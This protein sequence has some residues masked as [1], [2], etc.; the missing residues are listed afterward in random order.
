MARFPNIAEAQQDANAVAVIEP[1]TIQSNQHRGFL[2]ADMRD[3]E[4]ARGAGRGARNARIAAGD[5][6]A[7]MRR[8]DQASF[9]GQSR[10]EIMTMMLH[11]IRRSGSMARSI[12]TRG[13]GAVDC[14]SI[15]PS[16]WQGAQADAFMAFMF[17]TAGLPER[18]ALQN[19]IPGLGCYARFVLDRVDGSLTNQAQ[20]IAVA[21]KSAGA[22]VDPTD[23]GLLSSLTGL[24]A[25]HGLTPKR[26]VELYNCGVAIT[27]SA[28][29]GDYATS[30]SNSDCMRSWYENPWYLGAGAAVLIGAVW[31]ATKKKRS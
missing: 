24:V 10:E 27:K 1:L 11:G 4:A 16:A 22:M 25:A 6:V 23:S 28:G 15:P 18:T 17:S 5:P 7:R 2:N 30:W 8:S 19:A 12:Q 3:F 13:L 26:A 20:E 31:F 29:W 9:V 21:L 14:S